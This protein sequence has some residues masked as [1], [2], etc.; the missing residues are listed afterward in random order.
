MT[1]IDRERER[2][3]G[4]CVE[5]SVFQ[6]FFQCTLKIDCTREKKMWLQ[7]KLRECGRERGRERK[8][9]HEYTTLVTIEERERERESIL[10]ENCA[11]CVEGEREC[12]M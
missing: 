1:K 10:R 4:E 3:S 9:L 7:E 6:F 8:R 5:K 11:S 12:G 2:E